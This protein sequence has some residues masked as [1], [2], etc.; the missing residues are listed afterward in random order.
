MGTFRA[1]IQL[2][3]ITMLVLQLLLPAIAHAHT[4][5][6]IETAS[7]LTSCLDHDDSSHLPD[8]REHSDDRCY[9]DTP[10]DRTLSSTTETVTFI[11]RLVPTD[12]SRLLEGYPR[13]IYIPPRQLS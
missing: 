8:N 2:V 5:A 10:F 13:R 4:L 6:S 3:A 1:F 12:S 9:L 11:G 7:Q